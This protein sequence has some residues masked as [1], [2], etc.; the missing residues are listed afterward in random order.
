MRARPLLLALVV[1]VLAVTASACSGGSGPA[2]APAPSASP[3]A[4][5]LPA[6]R[7]APELLSGVECSRDGDGTWSATGLVSNPTKN[8]ASYQVSAQVGP[9][10]GS[11]P[12]ATRRLD[13]V[14]AGKQQPF[15]LTDIP[16]SA[17]DGPCHLQLLVLPPS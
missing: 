2:S 16:T 17:P 15:L 5:G 13:D 4:E 12:A 6:G 1:P 9:A 8:T 11:S 14:A 10:D 3:T 7:S